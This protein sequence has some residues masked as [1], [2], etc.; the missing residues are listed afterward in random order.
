ML[1]DEKPRGA[2]DLNFWAEDNDHTCDSRSGGFANATCR[3]TV[4][5]ISQGALVNSETL[6]LGDF[7]QKASY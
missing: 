7:R 6:R 5:G 1:S 3:S 2:I 4:G